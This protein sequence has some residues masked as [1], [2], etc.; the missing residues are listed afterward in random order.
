MVLSPKAYN[1][2]T[3]PK[4]S[5]PILN[6]D[7]TVLVIKRPSSPP[8]KSIIDLSTELLLTEAYLSSFK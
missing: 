2:F 8:L 4:Y 3:I 5:K 7:S 6:H 1:N